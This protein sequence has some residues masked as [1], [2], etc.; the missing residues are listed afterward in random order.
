MFIRQRFISILLSL[1]LSFG[2]VGISF[3]QSSGQ[4][5]FG[6]D[7]QPGNRLHGNIVELIDNGLSKKNAINDAIDKALT[8]QDNTLP[9]EAKSAVAFDLPIANQFYDQML[10]ANSLI[11]VTQIL[12]NMHPEKIVHVITLGVILYPEFAQ[13]VFDGAALTGLMDLDDI[14]IAVLQAGADPTT[15]SAATAA[16]TQQ[17]P[18]EAIPLGTGIGAG[19]TGGGD[20]TASTN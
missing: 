9:G 3:A 10:D 14:L 18:T 20:T 19:G 8:Y 2:L 5:F 15:V 7:N 1:S 13:E 6:D 16:G 11:D 17:T 12:I 4:V